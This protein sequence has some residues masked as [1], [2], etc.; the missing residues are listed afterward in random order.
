M[1]FRWQIFIWTTAIDAN[2][3][4]SPVYNIGIQL[5]RD[6]ITNQW[7]TVTE[8]QGLLRPVL[9]KVPLVFP[10]LYSHY[11]IIQKNRSSRPFRL[12]SH[13]I[14][15]LRGMYTMVKCLSNHILAAL[16]CQVQWNLLE[17][18][19]SHKNGC[20]VALTNQ[21]SE[22]LNISFFKPFTVKDIHL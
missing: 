12:L 1:Y 18:F 22:G 13:W 19:R 16:Y 6:R 2:E 8:L 7:W 11:F 5:R 15:L 3:A 14:Y 17:A 21:T 4:F 10:F 9:R 20:Q